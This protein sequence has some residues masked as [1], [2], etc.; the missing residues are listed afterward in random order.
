MQVKKFRYAWETQNR[1]LAHLDVFWHQ[2][3]AAHFTIFF[4]TA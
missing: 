4:V 3:D 1:M 2:A